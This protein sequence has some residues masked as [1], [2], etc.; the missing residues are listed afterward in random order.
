MTQP[1][2]VDEL[3]ARGLLDPAT[4]DGGHRRQALM[5][6]LERRATLNELEA[7]AHDLGYVAALLMN[8]GTPSMTRAELADRCHVP[9]D[10]VDRLFLAI[11]LASP[12]ADVASANEDD[13]PV[14][15]TFA[16]A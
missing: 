10:V 9:N 1:Q 12:G 4:T 14:V 2:V 5:L 6:L 11:G 16:A 13:V 15:E 8:G 7:N 3:I